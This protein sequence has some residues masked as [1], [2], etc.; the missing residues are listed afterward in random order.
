MNTHNPIPLTGNLSAKK[1][2]RIDGR[3]MLVKPPYFTP[4]TP[5]LGIAI[6]KSFLEQNGFVANCFDFNIDPELWGMHHNY[7]ATLQKL[8]DVSI[9]DGYSKLWWVLDAH[10]LAYANEARPF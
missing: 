9:N 2:R 1:S 7:F 3:I 8:E 4:W 10:M 6:L 5:P